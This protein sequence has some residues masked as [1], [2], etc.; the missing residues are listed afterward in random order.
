MHH[1]KYFEELNTPTDDKLLAEFD[2]IKKTLGN[3]CSDYIDKLDNRLLWRG[4]II[5]P[6]SSGYSCNSNI[7]PKIPRKDRR[8]FNMSDEMRE[9]FDD[10]FEEEFGE[11]VRPRT[12]GV[13]TFNGP[14]EAKTY[15]NTCSPWMVFPKG[16]YTTLFSYLYPDLYINT[17]NTRYEGYVARKRTHGDTKELRN[18]YP[19]TEE[20]LRRNAKEK[21][22]V[23]TSTYSTEDFKNA[24][25]GCEIM[26]LCD[27][28]YLVNGKFNKLICEWLGTEYEVSI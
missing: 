10:C 17:P 6:N 23:A 25:G 20:E 24:P 4:Y 2:V 22:K 18:D 11:G 7:I 3:N 27:E 12:R 5:K 1:L 13:F 19:E 8:G 21:I 9:L 14:T 15:A 16:S 28:Y 26:L